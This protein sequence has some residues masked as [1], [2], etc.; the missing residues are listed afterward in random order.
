MQ[1]FVGRRGFTEDISDFP[2]SGCDGEDKRRIALLEEVFS[3][4]KNFVCVDGVGHGELLLE[5]GK[6][7]SVS[8][9]DSEASAEH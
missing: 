4:L 9:S 6:R 3:F 2:A 5:R 1:P 7:E 8:S